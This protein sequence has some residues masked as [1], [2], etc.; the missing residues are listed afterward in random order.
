[1]TFYAAGGIGSPKLT[2]HPAHWSASG[3]ILEPHRGQ[4]AILAPTTINVTKATSESAHHAIATI[5]GHFW[6]RPNKL[7]AKADMV[8]L[9][10]TCELRL[11]CARIVMAP[12]SMG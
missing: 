5:S 10:V 1:M 8:R 3:L 2:P 6:R 11:R 12:D 9:N 7:A 4:R